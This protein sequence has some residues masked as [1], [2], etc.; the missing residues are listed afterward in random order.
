MFRSY[1]LVNTFSYF[2]TC[3]FS[4]PFFRSSHLHCCSRDGLRH[5]F[6]SATICRKWFGRLFS[7]DYEYQCE[8]LVY[9]AMRLTSPSLLPSSG[10]WFDRTLNLH[11]R[12][13]SSVLLLAITNESTFCSVALEVFQVC[14]SV[15]GLWMRRAVH[16]ALSFLEFSNTTVFL[17]NPFWNE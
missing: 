13:T 9:F 4:T 15:F 17:R 11:N 12:F 5:V 3:T 16:W 7:F 2:Y 8:G 6:V 10:T 1:C 14:A